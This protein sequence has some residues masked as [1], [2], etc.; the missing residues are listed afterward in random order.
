MYPRAFVLVAERVSDP[1]EN[2]RSRANQCR[3]LA[4][5]T[6]D[7]HMRWQLIEWANGIE[8]DE[9]LEAERAIRNS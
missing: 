3:R 8:A 7:E 2:M 9:R 1:V 4:A 6:H 5:A